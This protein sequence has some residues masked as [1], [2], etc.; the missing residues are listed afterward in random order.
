[1]KH[2]VIYV[3]SLD[4]KTVYFD[5]EKLEA[6]I[7]KALDLAKVMDDYLAEDISY[8]LEKYLEKLRD[9]KHEQLSVQDLNGYVV[10]LLNDAGYS[11]VAHAYSSIHAA[12]WDFKTSKELIPWKESRVV[13]LLKNN[14]LFQSYDID[15]LA[16][17]IVEVVTSLK[18]SRISDAFIVEIANHLITNREFGPKSSRVDAENSDGNKL[19]YASEAIAFSSKLVQGWFEQKVLSVGDVGTLFPKFLVEFNFLRYIKS[20]IAQGEVPLM[21]MIFLPQFSNF[22]VELVG[23]YHNVGKFMELTFPGV[24][25]KNYLNLDGIDEGVAV[26][27]CLTG[28]QKLKMKNEIIELIEGEFTKACKEP[29]EITY[30]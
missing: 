15:D 25:V 28:R 30:K 1:M 27:F 19:L 20:Y 8:A 29:I 6:G 9:G 5:R 16:H 21:E 24:E 18:F 11:E 2:S 23:L 10:Q 14:L 13:D 7:I 17:S 12:T 3:K 26:S 22:I 4:G